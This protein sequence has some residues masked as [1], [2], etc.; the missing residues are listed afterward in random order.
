MRIG[1]VDA[2]HERAQ[3]AAH[4]GL[5]PSFGTIEGLRTVSTITADKMVV[6]EE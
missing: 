6:L 5:S 4:V 1:A 3:Y 2:G